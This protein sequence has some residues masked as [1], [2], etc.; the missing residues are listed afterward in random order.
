MIKAVFYTKNEEIFGFRV[1]GHAEYGQR[2]KDVVC[3][4]VSALVINAVNSLEKLTEDSVIVE[5]SDDGSVRCKIPG[6]PTKEGKLILKSLQLGLVSVYESYGDPYIQIYF[7]E[8]SH[9]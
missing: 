6:E 5:E 1:T 8:V 9:D 2:G 3:A 7:R 4:G